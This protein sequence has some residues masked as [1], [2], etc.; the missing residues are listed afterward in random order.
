MTTVYFATN[1]RPNDPD[2]PTYFGKDFSQ[3]GLSDLR[4]GY[5]EV[6]ENFGPGSKLVVEPEPYDLG[7]SI[8][9]PSAATFDHLRKK[10]KKQR[11]PTVVFIH[12]YN[13]TFTE[14]LL[15]AAKLKQ[16]IGG[17]N[18]VV[19]AWPSDGSK[20]PWLAYRSDRQ[21]A[22]ASGPAIARGFMKLRDFLH[23]IREEDH[24]RQPLHLVCHSMGA[25]VLRHAIQELMT[26]FW[27]TPP[28]VFQQVVLV[29]A[30]E[31]SDSLNSPDK[32]QPLSYMA[33]QI[34]VYY[35]DGDMPLQLSDKTKAN[36]NRLGQV[37]PAFPRSLPRNVTSVDFSDVV[38][39]RVEHDYFLTNDCA[40]NDLRQVLSGIAPSKITDREYEPEGSFYLKLPLDPLDIPAFDFRS[41]EVIPGGRK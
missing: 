21:D 34:T 3:N 28:K 35:N 5:A 17:V 16:T 30:D 10:M 25:F 14:S 40:K 36:P 18:V 29:A 19:F 1:R 37:G 33:K 24:C 22:R 12:G 7:T 9:P 41:S 15:A 11:R 27:I 32:L 20:T 38:G 39:G 13:M 2:E 4:F 26:E 23:A 31:D 8:L 6:E